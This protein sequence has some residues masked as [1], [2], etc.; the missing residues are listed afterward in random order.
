MSDGI[1][2]CLSPLFA[3]LRWRLWSLKRPESVIKSYT[4]LERRFCDNA[5]ST[6]FEG[7]L[8]WFLRSVMHVQLD[9]TKQILSA[10]NDQV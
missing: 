6:L 3:S 1:V 2:L 5:T 8:T 4:Q 7:N 9:N 10:R